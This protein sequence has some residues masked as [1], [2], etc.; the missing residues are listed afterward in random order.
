MSDFHYFLRIDKQQNATQP[1]FSS[2]FRLFL[3]RDII[4]MSEQ[5]RNSKNK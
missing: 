2:Y 4:R 1:K 5:E 3:E